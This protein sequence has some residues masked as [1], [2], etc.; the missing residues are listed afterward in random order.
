MELSIDQIRSQLEALLNPP[1]QDAA[2]TDPYAM[3]QWIREIY[4]ESKLAIYC[5]PDGKLYRQA[6]TITGMDVALSGNAEE[7]MVVYQGAS[8]APTTTPD[9]AGAAEAPPAAEQPVTT[10][11]TALRR[12]LRK[13]AAAD[14]LTAA[15]AEAAQS[16]DAE[17]T[18]AIANI[19]KK[20][21]AAAT[22]A[23][24]GTAPAD[25][26]DAAQPGALY[27]A[28]RAALDAA[29]PGHEFEDEGDGFVVISV[30]G[31]DGEHFYKVPVTID[32]AGT[33][34]LGQAEEVQP[35]TTEPPATPPAT[36]T[37]TTRAK[38]TDLHQVLAELGD[39]PPTEIRIWA[40]GE[41][42]TSKGTFKFTRDD[43]EA[44]MGAYADQGNELHFDYEH[45]TF[46]AE[47]G[48]PAPAAGWFQLEL[49]DDGLYAV[50]I[51]WTD[52]AG[53]MI[54][55]KEYRY[56]SPAFEV[57]ADDHIV[58]LANIAL[59]NLPATKRH[60]PLV[61]ASRRALAEKD[62]EIRRLR[63]ETFT[64][65]RDATLAR[66]EQAGVPPAIIARARPLL[67]ADETASPTVKLTRAGKPVEVRPGEHAAA[68]LL[69]LATAR[70]VPLGE[71]TRRPEDHSGKS[72]EDAAAE[73]EAEWASAGRRNPRRKD[74]LIEARKRYPHLRGE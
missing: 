21:Q 11:L 57:D 36:T 20:Q 67:D 23:P 44:L 9:N 46:D 3:Y 18:A 2:G 71:R 63:H 24:A 60:T 58:G 30:T 56:T 29:F 62:A 8:D 52:R 55:N 39:E 4:P 28:A 33:A 35:A 17:M 48:Q 16:G 12:P 38:I 37:M 74:V 61:A 34:T 31:E 32:A 41:V 6:F 19:V 65:E 15:M 1:A 50:N 26:A 22:D 64:R 53:E 14:H 47:P 13:L 10:R 42:A 49:R 5:A 27:Q 25:E 68:L 54:R 40:F 45:G 43:G 59:T 66:L 69:E 70:P 51:K 72:L 73:V 7:V